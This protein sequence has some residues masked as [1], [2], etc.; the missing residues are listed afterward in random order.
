MIAFRDPH[1]RSFTLAPDTITQVAPYRTTHSQ[2]RTT[3][4][5]VAGETDA[6]F[7]AVGAATTLLSQINAAR[8]KDPLSLAK[9]VGG[10]P[11]RYRSITP[12]MT[13]TTAKKEYL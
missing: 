5:V 6:I 11:A 12:G 4:L 9:T 7:L 1:G 13:T 3:R 2:R 8:T 10:V